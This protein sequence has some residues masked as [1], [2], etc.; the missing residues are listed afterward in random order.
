MDGNPEANVSDQAPRLITWGIPATGLSASWWSLVLLALL[1]SYVLDCV[2]IRLR[3]FRPQAA[4]D[5]KVE[6][7]N[8]GN[9]GGG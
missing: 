6:Q 2:T 4:E 9:R 5:R 8:A 3:P 7:G 1:I